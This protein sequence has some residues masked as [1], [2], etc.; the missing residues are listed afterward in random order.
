MSLRQVPRVYLGVYRSYGGKKWPQLELHG[1][2]DHMDA[3]PCGLCHGEQREAERGRERERG[4]EGERER[5]R[6]GEEHNINEKRKRYGD[7]SREGG[8][9]ESYGEIM[10]TRNTA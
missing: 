6:E 3:H 7:D 5:E 9:C 2:M 1:G 10:T 4:R 8:Y